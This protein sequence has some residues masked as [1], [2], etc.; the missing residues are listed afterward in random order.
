MY[1]PK[2]NKK[3]PV[4][5]FRKGRVCK[6]FGCKQHL[7]VYNSEEYCHAHQREFLR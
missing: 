1:L 3:G 7:N 6:K 4:K 2:T 5:K